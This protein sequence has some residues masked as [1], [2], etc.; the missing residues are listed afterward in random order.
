MQPIFPRRPLAALLLAGALSSAALIAG[1]GESSEKSTEPPPPPAP[2]V[3]GKQLRFVAGHP[4]LALLAATPAKA[5]TD[6]VAEL[7]ARLV[8]NEERTQRIYPAFGGRVLSIGADIGA[9]VKPGTALAR[10]ASPDFGAAQ[11]DTT[12]A[13][14]DVALARKSLARQREL[15]DAGI[16]ARKDLDQ[17]E[18]DLARAQAESARAAAR[19]TLYGSATGVNQQ[20]GL[21][22]NIAGVVVERNINPGQEVRPDQSGPG[23]PALFVVTDPT[24]LWVQIDAKET[25][26]GSL[27]PGASFE[28]LVP[29]Y[30]G[31]VFRGKVAAVSDAIDPGTRTIKVRGVIANVDRRLKSEMLVTARVHEQ[32][33][34]V[35]VPATAIVLDRT[36]HFVYVQVQPGVFEPRRVTLAH[37]GSKEVV[38]GSGVQVGEQV[39]AD[40]ALLLA[41]E[42]SSATEDARIGAQNADGKA[43]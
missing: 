3:Q 40:N 13:G 36:Q 19:T 18:A 4:Q 34:G 15:F 10:I 7:P 37:M 17:T 21:A 8:W 16:I 38:L 24:S 33:S 39:V 5:A 1:C 26:V 28:L 9:A 41:R 20:L 2:I 32:L 30:P 43:K 14:V 6:I 29:A 27:Q 35:V 22:S 31:E 12:K 23:T 11:S 42:F 25:D